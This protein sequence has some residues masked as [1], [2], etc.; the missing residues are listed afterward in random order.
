MGEVKFG[1]EQMNN[2]PPERYRRFTNGM[3]L[4]IVPALVGVVQGLR[5]D[6]DKRNFWMLILAAMPPFLK[7]VGIWL[8]NGQYI[9]EDSDS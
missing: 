1:K 5:M 9:R 4:F 6:D 2:P 3:I 8:G 7:G